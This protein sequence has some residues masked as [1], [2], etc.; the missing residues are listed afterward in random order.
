VD[1]TKIEK[2]R[3]GLQQYLIGVMMILLGLIMVVAHG[4]LVGFSVPIAAAKYAIS[5]LAIVLSHCL[6]IRA[7]SR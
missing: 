3:S 1:L 6:P 4:E 2:Q 7:V 5:A